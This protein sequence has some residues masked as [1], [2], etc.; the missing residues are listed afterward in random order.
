[1]QLKKALDCHNLLRHILQCVII[2]SGV[3]WSQD[4]DLLKLVLELGEPLSIVV[5]K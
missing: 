4:D 5:P 2:S 3:D 1:M